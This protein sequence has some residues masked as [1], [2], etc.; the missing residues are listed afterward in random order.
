MYIY[1]LL[2]ISH[3]SLIHASVFIC[4]YVPSD[5]TFAFISPHARTP[6]SPSHSQSVPA[7]S[8]VVA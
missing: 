8:V 7:I 2:L 3:H 5:S 4:E 6:I 1:Y